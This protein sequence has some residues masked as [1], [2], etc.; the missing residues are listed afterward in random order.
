MHLLSLRQTHL[1]N[2]LLD[3]A[4][5]ASLILALYNLIMGNRKNNYEQEG[6]AKE[7]A[8]DEKQTIIVLN[9][10]AQ[11]ATDAPQTK[12]DMENLLEEHRL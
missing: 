6:A 1:A 5:L 11:A 9:D 10:E 12:T 2:R 7:K 3:M 8:A 4:W